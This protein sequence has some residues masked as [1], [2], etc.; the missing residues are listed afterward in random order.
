MTKSSYRYVEELEAEHAADPVITADGLAEMLAKGLLSPR[1]VL[2]A[3]AEMHC[4][5]QLLAVIAIG[6]GGEC[7]SSERLFSHI[8][9]L[10]RPY[11]VDR[12]AKR[13]AMDKLLDELLGEVSTDE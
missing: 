1:Q 2:E 3:Y 6:E 10:L 5:L 11:Y 13:A 9:D 4:L 12:A 7:Y 8:A